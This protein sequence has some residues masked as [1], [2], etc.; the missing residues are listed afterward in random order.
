MMFMACPQWTWAKGSCAECGIACTEQFESWQSARFLRKTSMA[1]AGKRAV[2]A[3][4]VEL[5]RTKGC[6]H[7]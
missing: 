5:F 7:V 1:K 6:P 3:R 2:K 4:M